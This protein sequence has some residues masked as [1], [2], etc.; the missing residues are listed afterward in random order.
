MF[1]LLQAPLDWHYW[2]PDGLQSRLSPESSA[3]AR[4]KRCFYYQG[5]KVFLLREQLCFCFLSAWIS[6]HCITVSPCS[7]MQ[8]V[9]TMKAILYFS[10]YKLKNIIFTLLLTALKHFIILQAHQFPSF[11]VKWQNESDL[12]SIG[13]YRTT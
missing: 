12:E 2:Q 4:K 9:F 13:I 5:W 3:F 11:T 8:T 1:F 6:L 10:N 7:A